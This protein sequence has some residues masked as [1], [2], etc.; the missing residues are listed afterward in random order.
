[1]MWSLPLATVAYPLPKPP[2]VDPQG[3]VCPQFYLYYLAN[4]A[5]RI[6]ELDNIYNS[7]RPLLELSE[8]VIGT[9]RQLRSLASLTPQSWQRTHWPQLSIDALLQY[10]HQ[11]LTVRT[12]LQLALKYHENQEFAFN[13]AT[14]LDSCQELARRYV[15]MRPILPA[16]FFANRLIDLQAFTATVFLLLAS[17]RATPDSSTLPRAVHI[18]VTT[19]IVDQASR[20]M[21]YAA[22]QVGG[23]FAHQAADAVRS[24]NSLLQQPQSFKSQKVT[25]SLPLVG[26]IHVSRKFHVAG[27]VPEQPYTTPSQEPHGSWQT[28][29]SSDVLHPAQAMSFESQDLDSMDSL[30]FSMEIPEN[31]PFLT[32]ETYETQPWFTSMEWNGKG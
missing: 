27:F 11:Y 14:C 10:W 17:Y 2:I 26:R 7:G 19:G 16:G 3:Q 15:S 6:L 32:D 25:L 8:A 22:N 20:M 24:L 4:I 30:S 31:H 18:S 28:T 13:F 29:T 23:D 9:D 21:G 12:H 1:M 5:S